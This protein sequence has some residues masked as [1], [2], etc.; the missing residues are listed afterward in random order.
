MSRDNFSEYTPVVSQYNPSLYRVIVGIN[1]DNNYQIFAD[2]GLLR[3]FTDTTLPDEVKSK[4]TM[5]KAAGKDPYPIDHSIYNT[6]PHEEMREIG[7][8]K[9]NGMYCVVLSK[10]A[11]DKLRGE[12]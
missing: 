2:D 9:V 12:K 4:L 7:W 6:T 3:I 8:S 10:D 1:Q 5:I 11:L